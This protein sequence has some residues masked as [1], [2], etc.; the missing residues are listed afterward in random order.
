[1]KLAVRVGLEQRDVHRRRCVVQDDAEL[2]RLA[3]TSAHV[4]MRWPS[5]PVSSL[6]VAANRSRRPRSRVFAQ[7]HLVRGMRGIGLVL[8]DERSRGVLAFVDR[9]VGVAE[10]AVSAGAVELG[11]PRQHH[12][13]LAGIGDLVA[14]AGDA[15]GAD[16]DQRIIRLAAG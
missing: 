5:A 14:G 10:D 11:R 12:E 1:M 2:Q 15:I 8:V 7:E 9:V 16:Q 4:A 13:L 6:P 3:F